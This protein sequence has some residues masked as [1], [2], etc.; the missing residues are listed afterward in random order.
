MKKAFVTGANGFLGRYLINFLK[1]KKYNIIFP[2]SKE[3]NLVNEKSLLNYGLKKKYIFDEI[4]HLAA[5][6]QA[7]D[8]CLKYP[9]DQWII[10]QKINTNVLYWWKNYQ[11]QAKLIFIGT[12]C[13]YAENS[14]YKEIN[15]MAG[16]PTPSLYTYAMTKR[17]LLQGAISMQN[18]FGMKWLCLVPSTLYG[19]NYHQDNRQ[20]HFIF[21]LV[22]K[23]VDGKYNKTKVILWGDGNQ[24]REIINVEDFICT[25]F[26]LRKK[27]N[28][29]VNIGSGESFSIKYFARIISKI[30]GFSHN[31]IIYDKTKYVGTRNKKLDITKVSGYLKNYTNE[32]IDIEDGL[33]E[34]VNWYIKKNY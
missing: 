9:G 7:G 3:C 20:M 14:N 17:M 22:K 2:G 6:T 15:Y 28:D 32:L 18:Q 30:V 31:K 16:E 13:A 33:K 23:I 1:K 12:S 21:D 4:Y 27:N 24:K 19:I 25:L 11:P 8:F 5:W 29:I 10:N 34:V 26:N